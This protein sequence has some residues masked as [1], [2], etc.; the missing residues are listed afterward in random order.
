[1]REKRS[2]WYPGI[3][4][5]FPPENAS[6]VGKLTLS[7]FL[8]QFPLEVLL[9]IP[10]KQAFSHLCLKGTTREYF[11]WKCQTVSTRQV[12]KSANAVHIQNSI[13][14]ERWTLE[15][16]QAALRSREMQLIR[17]RENVDFLEFTP[18]DEIKSDCEEDNWHPPVTR[19]IKKKQ[20]DNL[21]YIFSSNPITFVNPISLNRITRVRTELPSKKGIGA[22]QLSN[23]TA[24]FF[25]NTSFLLPA[26]Y[27]LSLH[28]LAQF[29]R[30]N[31]ILLWDVNDKFLP[32]NWF[33]HASQSLRFHP[34]RQL[35]HRIGFSCERAP[36]A[37]ETKIEINLSKPARRTSSFWENLQARSQLHSS[38]WLYRKLRL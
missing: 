6:S 7:Q 28:N 17:H 18:Q 25:V 14:T 19:L 37:F 22:M 26:F 23:L 31:I 13:I 29:Y 15:A 20:S 35:L 11:V 9:R 30:C 36:Y 12:K 33:D 24:S 32:L 3:T 4:R 27:D 8:L 34:V 16:S 2:A 1:M 21:F 38:F 10:K 5:L